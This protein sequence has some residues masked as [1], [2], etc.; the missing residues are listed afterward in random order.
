MIS[1]W[2]G[3]VGI[4]TCYRLDGPGMGAKFSIPGQ[5][6]PGVHPA[7]CTMCSRSPSWW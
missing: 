6:C 4:A 2:D 1:S 3:V 7:S 5:T